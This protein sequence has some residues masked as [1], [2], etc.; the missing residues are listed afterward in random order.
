MLEKLMY[1]PSK[2]GSSDVHSSMKARM[3]SSVTAP[4]SSNDGRSRA[5]NSS[6]SQ[7]A[8]TPRVTLPLDSTSSVARALAATIGLRWGT[9]MTLVPRRSV[10]VWPAMNAS[11]VS[12]SRQAPPAVPGCT[13]CS[14]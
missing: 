14:L 1:L 2:T 13:C 4:L 8:P 12:W 5:S 7:P 10:V 6:L 9:I 11:T 3:Y